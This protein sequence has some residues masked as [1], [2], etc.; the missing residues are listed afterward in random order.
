MTKFPLRKSSPS[1]QVWWLNPPYGIRIGKQENLPALYAKLGKVLSENFPG[2]RASLITADE[3]LAR[4]TGLKADKVNVLY[5]GPIKCTLAHFHLFTQKERSSLKE[6]PKT[7][8]S[9]GAEMFA[10]RLKKNF[11]RLRKWAGKEGI[12]S[13]RLYDSDMPEYNVSIDFF[14]SKWLHVQEYAPPGT[15]DPKMAEARFRE[16]VSVIP[17]VLNVDRKNIFYKNRKRQKGKTQYQRIGSSGEFLT[18]QEG[19]NRFL[20]NFTDHL[21]CGIFLDGRMTTG[22][23]PETCQGKAVSEPFLLYGNGYRLCSGRGR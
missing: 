18:M 23:H 10:N 13:Y 19:G 11:K 1:R 5:N 7:P 8:L 21:D 22:A 3:E 9:P 20:I 15:V 12:S 6:K 14:E 17:T 16:I 4:N 2:W